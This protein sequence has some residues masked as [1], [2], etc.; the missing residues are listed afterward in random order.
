MKEAIYKICFILILINI[1]VLG[2][3]DSIIDRHVT[4]NEALINH[5]HNTIKEQN[6]MIVQHNQMMKAVL[7]T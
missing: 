5:M 2:I 4:S 7:F 3:A 1:I 6:K